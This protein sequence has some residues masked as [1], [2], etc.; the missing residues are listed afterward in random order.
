MEFGSPIDRR[1]MVLWWLSAHFERVNIHILDCWIL[2]QDGQ[3]E[4][5]SEALGNGSKQMK[6]RRAG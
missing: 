4:P 3:L 6:A 2:G 5:L 1:T